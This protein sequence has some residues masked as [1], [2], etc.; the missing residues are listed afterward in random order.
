MRLDGQR[1]LV[2][3]EED[4]VTVWK[5]HGWKVTEEKVSGNEWTV[6]AKPTRR[7]KEGKK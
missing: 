6:K 1:R 4:I 5:M 3:L 2:T 7:K